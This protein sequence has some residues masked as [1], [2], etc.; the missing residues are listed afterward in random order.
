[1]I[2]YLKTLPQNPL[3]VIEVFHKPRCLTNLN[4]PGH[5]PISEIISELMVRILASI[6]SKVL[7]FEN[8]DA[9]IAKKYAIVNVT[10]SHKY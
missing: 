2:R 8:L 9:D 10:M 4:I 3:A 5:P 1:M 7:I 6:T